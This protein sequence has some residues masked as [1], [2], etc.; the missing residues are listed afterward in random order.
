[1]LSLKRLDSGTSRL[2]WCNGDK[3][4]HTNEHGIPGEGG[5]E[6]EGAHPFVNLC[7]SIGLLGRPGVVNYEDE[8]G[9][10]VVDDLVSSLGVI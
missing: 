7:L 1:M 4:W 9:V 8:F 3:G 10:E 5:K 2:N 6:D